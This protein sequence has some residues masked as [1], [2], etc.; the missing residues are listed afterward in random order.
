MSPPPDIL[1]YLIKF[2]AVGIHATAYMLQS[3]IKS[4]AARPLTLGLSWALYLADRDL[5]V[6]RM[7][8][9]HVT[10]VLWGGRH[11]CKALH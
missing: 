11:S 3:L 5:L 9:I 8:V 2:R 1:P 10:A 7:A 4:Q 6:G